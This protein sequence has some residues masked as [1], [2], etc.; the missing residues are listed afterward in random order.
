MKYDKRQPSYSFIKYSCFCTIRRC[1]KQERLQ[2]TAEHHKM[3]KER[4]ER[5]REKM[6]DMKDKDWREG[7]MFTAPG[8]DK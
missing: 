1:T 7:K 4:N 2:R 5:I 3:A 6:R 8:Q